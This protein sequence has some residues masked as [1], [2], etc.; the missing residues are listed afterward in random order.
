M[1]LVLS[2]LFSCLCSFRLFSVSAVVVFFCL[3]DKPKPSNR[4]SAPMSYP[5]LYPPGSGPSSAAPSTSPHSSVGHAPD[6]SPATS[7]TPEYHYPAGHDHAR[8]SPPFC[9]VFLI[10]P[11]LPPSIYLSLFVLFYYFAF[12][13]VLILFALV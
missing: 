5:F 1:L 13:E 11:S 8:T 10:A 3:T 4:P 12:A 6:S 7:H 2:P 9:S